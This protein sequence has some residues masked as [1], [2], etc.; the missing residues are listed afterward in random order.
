MSVLR[1]ERY[2]LI[3]TILVEVRICITGI[4][5]NPRLDAVDQALERDRARGRERS[6][7]AN[8]RERYDGLM[9]RE[10]EVMEL[11][12]SG[13]LNRQVASTLGTSEVTAKDSP[14]ACDAKDE[15]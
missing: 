8:L 5:T 10:R 7:I 9:D 4:V 1:L 13:M 14:R 12:V 15:G 11:V 2:F 3:V 6:E